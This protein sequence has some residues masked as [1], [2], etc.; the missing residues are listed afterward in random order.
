[1]SDEGKNGL[2]NWAIFSG[3]AIQMGVTIGIGAFIGVKLDE[4]Y[5][6]Q[7][8]AFTVVFS[9]LGVFVSIYAL[10]KQLERLNKKD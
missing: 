10:I 4:K 6:N 5:P 7:Y 3:I 9:L 1:M 8:S 2:K